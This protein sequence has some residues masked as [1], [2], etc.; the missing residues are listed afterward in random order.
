MVKFV[1]SP[2]PFE[3]KFLVHDYLYLCRKFKVADV[4]STLLK[5]APASCAVYVISKGKVQAVRLAD[6]SQTL[7]PVA[8]SPGSHSLKGVK[9][10]LHPDIQD[11]DDTNRYSKKLETT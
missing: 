7:A 1:F 4:P 5:A 2:H 9:H 10:G 6:Q 11:P 3:Q 8:S